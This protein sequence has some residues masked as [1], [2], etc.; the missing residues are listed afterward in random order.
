VSSFFLSGR[1]M[2]SNVEVATIK[3]AA[4]REGWCV[5]V[6]IKEGRVCRFSKEGM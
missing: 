4:V 3:G 5:V 2:D 1:G 6:N